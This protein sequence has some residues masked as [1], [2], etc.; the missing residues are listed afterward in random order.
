[1][2]KPSIPL[3][4]SCP[5]LKHKQPKPQPTPSPNTTPQPLRFPIKVGITTFGTPTYF[6]LDAAISEFQK[7]VEANSKLNLQITLTKHPTLSLDEY[8]EISGTGGCSLFDPWYVHPET[9]AKLPLGV[10]VQI[11]IYDIQ[12]TKT[13]YGGATYPASE[14]TQNVPFIAVAF[15]DSISWWPV[16]PNWKTRT[17]TALVH[18]FYHA[19]SQILTKKGYS[20]PDI[21]KANN[22]GYN[23]ENDPGWIKFDKYIYGLITDEMHKKLIQ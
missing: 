20:M 19:L 16:E 22:Y 17:A 23:N 8:H 6:N 3:K 15:G 12:T 5:F 21:D 2:L 14:K 11:A 10:A 1:M 9:L 7:F 18:E 13:L 4:I